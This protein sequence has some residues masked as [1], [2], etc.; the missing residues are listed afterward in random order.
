MKYLAFNALIFE[1][2]RRCNMRPPCPHCIRGNTQ[3]VDLS[4]EAIDGVLGQT[5]MIGELGFI[6]G[7][8]LCALD[9]IKYIL[10]RVK[11]LRILVF[12][13]SIV[14]NGLFPTEPV[15]EILREW[16][17]YILNCNKIAG[18]LCYRGSNSVG[19]RISLDQYHSHESLV[20]QHIREY[21]EALGDLVKVSTSVIGRLPYRIG[22][23]QNLSTSET[24]PA[25]KDIKFDRQIAILD[26]EH[27]PR[28]LNFRDFDMM[29]ERQVVILCPLYVSALGNVIPG[30]AGNLSSYS[31]IDAERARICT[32][33]EPI[34]ES[35]LKYNEG[36]L[37]CFAYQTWRATHPDYELNSDALTKRFLKARDT[38]A[39]ENQE[40]TFDKIY[41]PTLT[42]SEREILACGDALQTSRLLN[43]LQRE[44]NERNYLR[45]STPPP[46][47]GAERV[48][49]IQSQVDADM[50]AINKIWAER[51]KGK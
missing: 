2:T 15:I 45:P 14:T 35:I 5:E 46:P 9:K 38:L 41:L 23:A 48:R 39:V 10:E 26:S 28:C 3:N 51:E 11:A 8:P 31:E 7:E 19:I 43:K 25:P 30:W 33:T 1:N 36:R 47:S 22:N 29:Y 49:K 17:E 20:R 42:T 16:A 44:S 13:L 50:A 24:L 18:M 34:F 21:T 6:G 4:T 12:S 37:D 40:S 32:A 27:K